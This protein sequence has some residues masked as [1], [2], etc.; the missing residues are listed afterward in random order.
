MPSHLSYLALPGAL[1]PR[2]L[3]PGAWRG[4]GLPLRGRL[5]QDLQQVDNSVLF[6]PIKDHVDEQA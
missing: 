4:A 3:L 6:E 2:L 5:Q 1:L